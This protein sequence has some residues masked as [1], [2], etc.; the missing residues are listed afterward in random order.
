MQKVWSRIV[1]ATVRATEVTYSRANG[2]HPHIHV[3]ARLGKCETWTRSD[4]DALFARWRDAVVDELGPQA[5][6]TAQRG[7]HFTR[8][9]D[10]SVAPAHYLTKLGLELSNQGK[11]GRRPGSVSTWR[12]AELAAEGDESARRLWHAYVT[13]TKGHQMIRLD[14]RAQEH[15]R[16]WLFCNAVATD[17]EG[18]PARVTD[19][20]LW[21]EEVAVLRRGE[22][23]QPSLVD[24]VLRGCETESDARAEVARWVSWSAKVSTPNPGAEPGP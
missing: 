17:G 9:F 23:F 5:E 10:A 12:L 3:L 2:W 16:W 20:E 6:P 1:R 11:E 4:R 21:P 15:A 14:D 7:L 8:E 18:E 22:C 19:V 24:D 13:S